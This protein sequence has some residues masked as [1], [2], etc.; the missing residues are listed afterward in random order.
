MESER[1]KEREREEERGMIKMEN[2]E[3]DM[4]GSGSDVT[5]DGNEKMYLRCLSN[6]DRVAARRL[7]ETQRR[8]WPKQVL[9]PVLSHDAG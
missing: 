8:V 9:V 4:R 1:L 6:Q 7:Q 2:A 3:Q 5:L